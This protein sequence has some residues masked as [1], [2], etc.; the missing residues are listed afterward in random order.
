MG[1]LVLL[2]VVIGLLFL[3]AFPFMWMWS[4][5]IVAALTVAKPIDYWPAFCM[6]IFIALFVSGSR[7]SSKSS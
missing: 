4:Y 1:A 5:A 3:V 7:S 6:M 2:V